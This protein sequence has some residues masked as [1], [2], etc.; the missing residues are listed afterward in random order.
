MGPVQ[1]RDKGRLGSRGS[2]ESMLLGSLVSLEIV[3]EVSDVTL[4]WIMCVKERERER[5]REK[6]KK[7]ERERERET[8]CLPACLSE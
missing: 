8:A 3:V 1:Q 4:R 6:K 5:E 2:E 7:E